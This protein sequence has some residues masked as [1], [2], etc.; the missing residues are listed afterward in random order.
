MVHATPSAQSYSSPCQC[1][2]AKM[3]TSPSCGW[4]GAIVEESSVP[5]RGMHAASSNAVGLGTGGPHCSR[6]C[7]LHRLDPPAPCP[8]CILFQPSP[9]ASPSTPLYQHWQIFAGV[10]AFPHAPGDE[11]CVNPCAAGV[12]FIIVGR[13][14]V[15]AEC[16]FLQHYSLVELGWY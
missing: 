4:G 12:S 6:T 10:S 9:S 14:L 7:P 5:L 11:Q 8:H 13:Q 15:L 3:A 2:E 16:L 1:S